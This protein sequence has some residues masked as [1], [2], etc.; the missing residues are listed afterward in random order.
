MIGRVPIPKLREDGTNWGLYVHMMEDYIIASERTFRRHLLGQIKPPQRPKAAR[1][2]GDSEGGKSIARFA[3]RT[4]ANLELEP[5]SGSDN[6]A[7]SNSDDSDELEKYEEK[8]DEYERV[9]ASIR[10]I[11]L[12]SIPEK[13]QYKLI[14]E[15]S[16]S[17]KTMWENLKRIYEGSDGEEGLYIQSIEKELCAFASKSARADRFHNRDPMK[18]LDAL[19]AKADEYT[20][21]VGGG[22]LA[23]LDPSY[24]L[25]RAMSVD[26]EDSECGYLYGSLLAENG[27]WKWSFKEK[28]RFLQKGIEVHRQ[29]KWDEEKERIFK[30]AREGRRR[31][32]KTAAKTQSY[33]SREEFAY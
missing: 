11:I 17:A 6:A 14:A 24:V 21:S 22:V 15:G 16:Q 10:C 19:L 28:I 30:A 12:C 25:G 8:L 2:G 29:K 33:A 5:G 27:F 31:T 18:T 4:Y 7:N 23:R 3:A 9:E 32:K 1:P 20:A 26:D 13:I